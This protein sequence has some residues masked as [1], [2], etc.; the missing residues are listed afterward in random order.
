[1]NFEKYK[2]SELI[3]MLTRVSSP[4]ITTPSNTVEPILEAL[5]PYKAEDAE[6]FIVITLN[7]GHR[8]IN[9]HVVTKGLVNHTLV[10]PRE[11]FRV[12]ILDNSTAIIV[13][14]NHP[15]GFLK[16]STDDLNVTKRLIQAGQLIGIKVIDH[17]IVGYPPAGHF[18]FLENGLMEETT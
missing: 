5:E 18:S 1:M 7:G 11:V 13:A 8:I 14:H 6:C 2:K 3:E 15:S 12:A 4:Q 16:P 10:H 9:T 17:V